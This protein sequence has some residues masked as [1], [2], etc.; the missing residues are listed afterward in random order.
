MV[1]LRFEQIKRLLGIDVPKDECV[2]ILT[3]LGL[4]TGN[5]PDADPGYF[6]PPSW[7][8]DLTREC[9]LIEE[10]GRIHGYEQVPEDADMP[11]VA[12]HETARE[13]VLSRVADVLTGAGYYEALTMSFVARETFNLFTPRPE[14]EPLSVEHSSRK[15]EN[16]LRQSLIPSLLI[17]R[18]ENERQGTFNAKLYE[19]ADVYLAARP[20]EARTQPTML[21]IVIGGSFAE[22]RGVF[23]ALAHCVNGTL[24]VNIRSSDVPQ[25]AEG[26]GAELLIGDKPWGWLGELDR[27]V[28]DRLDLRD[29]VTAGEVDLQPLVE[30]LERSPQFTPLPQYPAIERDL[31]FVLDEVVTWENLAKTVQA[32]AGPLLEDI[33]FVDQYRGQQIPAGKKSYVLS[34]AYRSPDRTLTGEEVDEAQSAVVAACQRDLGAVQR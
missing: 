12:T 15:Q 23:D 8:R 24:T 6:R 29:A 32:A 2:R 22:L 19:I 33:S 1:R 9:D 30:A 10:V 21:G 28:T 16:L 5:N 3:S 13:T 31:N 25:F 34:V 14:N 4:R 20:E 26:R 27:S 17:S 11:I 7:R 18:R